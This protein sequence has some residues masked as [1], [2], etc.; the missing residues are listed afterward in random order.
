MAGAEGGGVQGLQ[1]L[2]GL[3]TAPAPA[4]VPAA[5]RRAGRLGSPWR[6]ASRGGRPPSHAASAATSFGKRASGAGPAKNVLARRA[7]RSSAA[8]WPGREPLPR[9]M[10]PYP[11]F[12]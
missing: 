7:A 3:R 1:G 5:Y 9:R 2:Q 10:P 4:A 8:I 6:P 12:R 11:I